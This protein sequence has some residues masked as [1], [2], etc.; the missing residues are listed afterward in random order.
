LVY[1]AKSLALT[2]RFVNKPTV[3]T[4]VAACLLILTCSGVALAQNVQPTLPGGKLRTYYIA[5]VET[6]WNY[7]PANMDMMVGKP[8]EG[9]TKIW[10]E[11]RKDRIGNVY[12][13]AI[14]REYTDETFSTEKKR[15]KEWVHLG[16][17]GPLIRAEVGDTIVIHFRNNTTEP[18]SMH[19]HGVSYGR[20]SE[21]TPYA[22]T[23]MAGAGLVSPGQTH[24]Y[25]WSVP[26]ARV[27][28][29]H[30]AVSGLELLRELR[31]RRGRGYR[32]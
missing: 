19:P 27:L 8:F 9:E 31:F 20:D 24:M 7:V 18:Y 29:Y 12:R 17:M 6:E 15:T 5:A 1:R 23:S 32:P 10:T 13:K 30:E 4:V 25:I 21:G 2:R 22:D 3:R 11:H 28:E 14:Y 26:D 16:I